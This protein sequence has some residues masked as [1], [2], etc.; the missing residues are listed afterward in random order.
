MLSYYM[1]LN[2]TATHSE[3][4]VQRL[5]RIQLE[6]IIG[7]YCPDDGQCVCIGN[8]G[9]VGT[10]LDYNNIILYYRLITSAEA[11]EIRKLAV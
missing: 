5:N 10:R 2:L 1:C 7:C 4:V 8:L 9:T 11:V 6:W 3:L